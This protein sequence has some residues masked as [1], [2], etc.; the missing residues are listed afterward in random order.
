MLRVPPTIFW[1]SEA[2]FEEEERKYHNF[3]DGDD[4]V[5]QATKITTGRSEHISTILTQSF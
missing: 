2:K 4:E 3:G 1:S 5:N